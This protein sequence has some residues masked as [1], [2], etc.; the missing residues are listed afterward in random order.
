MNHFFTR[1]KRWLG[2]LAV[3]AA[4]YV[5]ATV[6]RNSGPTIDVITPERQQL[7]VRT[8]TAEP[9]A[10]RLTVSSQGEVAAQ[11]MI[12]LVSE[13]PGNVVSVAPAFVN[14][15]YFTKGDTLLEI[16]A[17]DYELAKIRAAASVAEA[18][19]DLE[20]EKSEAELASQ[21]L[22]PLREAKVASAEAR[23]ASAR[24][25]LSQAD[26]DL[27]RTRIKAPFDGRVL[28]TSA[29]FGQY[30]GK[31]QSVGRIFSTAIAEIR[32]PLADKQL[33]YLS[34]P[35][36]TGTNEA[37]PNVPVVFKADVGGST[38][39][40]SGYLHRMEGAVDDDSRVWYGVAR[41]DDP[42]GIQSD[43]INVPLAMGVFV[44]AEIEGRQIDSVYRL[45]RMALRDQ[46]YVLVVDS[47]SRL[48]R[49][50]VDVLRTDYETVFISE[51]L[52]PGDRVCV[53]P[54]EVFVDGLRVRAIDQAVAKTVAEK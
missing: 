50:E 29:D 24:A 15:G 12:D 1:N 46:E 42:Y 33:R 14:G 32:L 11:Y 34:L 43:T 18:N 23:V 27:R 45:P 20:I 7:T 25:A 52:N 22:F 19:E 2:P 5:V 44:E 13:L 28:F 16:D 40:W 3:V 41:V 37:L 35:F 9:S 10:A 30:I 54:V 21:G 26:A 49:R 51:G 38:A 53:S 48:R 39:E 36:G 31:G 17:T 6:I 4:A 8:V 47:D